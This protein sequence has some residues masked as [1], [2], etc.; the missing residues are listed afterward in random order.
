MKQKTL[1]A[2]CKDYGMSYGDIVGNQR[3]KNLFG[4]QNKDGKLIG[5]EPAFV[6]ARVL[7]NDGKSFADACTIM[8]MEEL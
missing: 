6:K 2:L 3:R 1:Y 7:M 4:V 8:R 5:Y